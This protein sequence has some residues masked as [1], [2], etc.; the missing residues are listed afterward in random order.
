MVSSWDEESKSRWI[1]ALPNDPAQLRSF[2][3][4]WLCVAHFEGDWVSKQ[5]GKKPVNPP[6]IFSGIPKSCLKQTADKPRQSER[7]SS[8]ARNSFA[9]EQDK[10]KSFQE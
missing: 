6:T 8:T 5:G 2:E 10:I 1:T 4:I 3:K 7:S 9:Q